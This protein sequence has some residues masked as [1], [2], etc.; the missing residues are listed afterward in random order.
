MNP[1]PTLDFP[2]QQLYRKANGILKGIDAAWEAD[3]VEEVHALHK[4]LILVIM[5]LSYGSF[6]VAMLRKVK[7]EAAKR[8]ESA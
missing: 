4:Q 8:Q 7:E 1:S 3:N 6:A 2:F 5:D